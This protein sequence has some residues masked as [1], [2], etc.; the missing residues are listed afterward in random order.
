M[1]FCS[2][3]LDLKLHHNFLNEFLYL[4]HDVS[5]KLFY[6]EQIYR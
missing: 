1:F 6:T 2:R 4:V 3:K 5:Y